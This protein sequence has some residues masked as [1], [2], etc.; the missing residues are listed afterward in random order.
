MR[1]LPKFD[2]TLADVG[3]I[4]LLPPDEDTPQ[5]NIQPV[6]VDAGSALIPSLATITGQEDRSN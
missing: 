4:T 3:V 1:I 2:D 5:R 6:A